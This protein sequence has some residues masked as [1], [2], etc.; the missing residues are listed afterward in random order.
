MQLDALSHTALAAAAAAAGVVCCFGG[1]ADSAGST[2]GLV[3]GGCSKAASMPGV[4]PGCCGEAAG[5]ARGLV[6][7]SWNPAFCPGG[8]WQQPRGGVT[9][10]TLL[11]WGEAA[12]RLPLSSSPGARGG[13]EKGE[14]GAGKKL[15][16]LAEPGLPH[17]AG[18][19]RASRGGCARR[20]SVGLTAPASASCL[21]PSAHAALSEGRELTGC[22]WGVPNSSSPSCSAS[23]VAE[24]M[25]SAMAGSV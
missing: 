14:G 8:A 2:P 1:S 23:E 10:M 6:L 21:P 20:E 5:L 11:G 3:T 15:E 18:A 13:A 4:P 12:S 24:P 22:D 19:W 25:P 9:D 7:A 16:G 17:S